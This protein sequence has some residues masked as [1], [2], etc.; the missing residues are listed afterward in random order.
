MRKVIVRL[1]NGLGNQLFT[2]AAAYSFAKKNKVNLY[3]DDE[4]GFYKRHKYEL[5]NFKISSS[6]IEKKYKFLGLSGR[7]KRMLLKK[8]SNNNSFLVEKLDEE[9]LTYYNP[10][11]F[12][13]KFEDILYFEGYFQSEKYFKEYKQS[14][15]NEF[16][17]KDHIEKDQPSEL[18]HNIKKSNSVS[19]HFRQEKFLKDENHKNLEQNN[20]EH[21]DNNLQ[22]IN[23]GIEYFDKN[24]EK[25]IYF[26]WSN[27]F[28]N[29]EKFFPRDKFILVKN[30][31][32]KDPAYDLYLMS[33]CKHYILSPST[34]HYWAA[35]LCRNK[36]K[37][38]LAPKNIRNKSGFYGFSNNKDIKASWWKDI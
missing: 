4:S 18:M 19:I 11:Q 16:T 21:L 24:I 26:V 8:F 3:V 37:I 6:I 36:S 23:R 9:K 10:D 34:L 29:L 15:L 17:F 25:P 20:L 14:I 35:F 12:E 27:N 1:G 13:K 31:V 33:L 5:H 30:N 38:C 22:I 2:Y 32:N 7:F 28:D